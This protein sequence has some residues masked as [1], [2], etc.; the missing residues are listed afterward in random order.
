MLTPL[1]CELL[2]GLAENIAAD[3]LRVRAQNEAHADGNFC[4]ARKVGSC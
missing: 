2:D 4:D 1:E 3:I